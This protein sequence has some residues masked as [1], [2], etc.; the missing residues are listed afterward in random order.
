MRGTQRDYSIAVVRRALDILEALAE[1][2]RPLGPT[3][4]A[5]RV[6]T[7]PSAAFRILKT[8]EER[9]YVTRDAVGGQYRLG[10]RLA[11]LGERCTGTLDLRLVARPVL[12]ELHC[13]FRETVNLGVLDDHQIVYIDMLESD[14]G[15][16]MAARVGARDHPHSTSLGKAILAFLP[17]PEL[18]RYLQRPLSQRTAQ[19]I[20]DPLSL[21][22][23]LERVRASGV[24][25]DHEENEEGA[26]C[27]GAPIFDHRGRVIAA[28]SIAGPAVRLAEPRRQEMRAAVKEAALAITRAVGGN[29]PTLEPVED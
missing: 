8:L 28:I 7:T 25:E 3:E 9:G 27:V 29:W 20:T 10:T 15:L 18:E 14:Q 23:E 6:G 5:R 17:E 13:R 16:R 12:E 26:C 4:L 21:R 22:A 24:A 11:Y 19:T 1:G 2:S